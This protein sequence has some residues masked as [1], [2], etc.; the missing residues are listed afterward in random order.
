MVIQE[1]VQQYGV[2][3]V[4]L[5]VAMEFVLS[6]IINGRA[7]VRM[8]EKAQADRAEMERRIQDNLN[9]RHQKIVALMN[10]VIDEKQGLI[11]EVRKDLAIANDN[12]AT[13][14]V[15][16]KQAN[17]RIDALTTRA[18]DAETE[19]S[20]LRGILK[21]TEGAL[22]LAN[23]RADTLAVELEQMNARLIALSTELDTERQLRVRAEK[24]VQNL[25]S[26]NDRA[27]ADNVVLIRRVDTLTTQ[28][29]HR[30]NRI[31]ALEQELARMK[32]R[33]ASIKQETSNEIAQIVVDI[34]DSAGVDDGV[35]DDGG[36]AGG[37]TG[38]GAAG[39]G[40]G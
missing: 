13:L 22:D 26:W 1:L 5:I 21:S 3:G 32:E 8:A 28:V 24:R 7:R 6:R 23:R 17:E 30:S 10:G 38:G 35:A 36:S 15:E 39:D 27:N 40:G 19:V 9:E 11:D 33:L 29:E 16:L 18:I 2:Y 37:G 14:K 12:I 34:G 4:A 31:L 25:E 20:Q